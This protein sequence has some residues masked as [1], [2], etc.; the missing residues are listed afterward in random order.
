MWTDETRLRH[1]RSCLRYTHGLTDEEW[2]ELGPLIPPAKPGGNK[3]TVDIREV[4]N[5]IMCLLGTGC[6]WRDIPKDLPPRSKVHDYLDRWD[7]DGTLDRIHHALYI[8][9]R[10]L[11]VRSTR[12]RTRPASHRRRN[13]L[14][15][16]ARP[17]QYC[18]DS[19]I[20]RTRL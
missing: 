10:E 1:D 20:E 19:L 11:A 18:M 8:K 3:P 7:H 14:N 9:C 16:A 6:Q 5:R 4:L 12:L 2:A 15:T 17:R 13:G